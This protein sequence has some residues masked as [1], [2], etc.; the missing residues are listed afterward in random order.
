MASNTSRVKRREKF[1][2]TVWGGIWG[3]VVGAVI[4]TVAS[5][6]AV[7]HDL[8]LPK[9][10]A[11]AVETPSGTE[12]DQARPETDPDIPG[13][14]T[15]P[16]AETAAITPATPA[17]ADASPSFDTQS[18]AAPSTGFDGP[19]APGRPNVPGSADVALTNREG[20]RPETGAAPEATAPLPPGTERPVA[21]ARDVPLPPVG[22]PAPEVT[23]T[24]VQSAAPQGLGADADAES[25][26]PSAAP[27]RVASEAPQPSVPSIAPEAPEAREETLALAE[28]IPAD[29]PVVAEDQPE[30]PL[31]VAQ[32][33]APVVPETVAE[34]QPETPRPAAPA[35]EAPEPAPA[36]A[37][38]PAI[39]DAGP[40]AS[41]T[42]DVEIAEV[43]ESAPETAA[44]APLALAPEVETTA[45]E[46]AAPVPAEPRQ[47]ATT[48]PR[49]IET[50]RDAE[51]APIG[52]AEAQAPAPSIGAPATRL[53]DGTA[54]SQTAEESAG[55]MESDALVANR[56]EFSA[57]PELAQM[58][59][60][61]LHEGGAL[62]DDEALSNLPTEVS[63]AVDAREPNA[64]AIADAYRSAG[65]EIVLIPALPPRPTPQDV[66]IAL[67]ANLST[68]A[69]TVAVMDPGTAGF[70]NDRA[71][72]GQVIAVLAETGHGLITAS[73]GLNTAQQIASRFEVPSALIFGDL[74]SASD[75]GAA[76][77]AL[78]RV[79][80]RARQ[81]SGIILVGPAN[82]AT[83]AALATWVQGRASAG[84]QLA[85]VS[86]VIAPTDASAEAEPDT[87]A[88]DDT[89]ADANE[90]GGLP[91]V[92]RLPQIRSLP[93]TSN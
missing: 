35:V 36:L 46:P 31:N 74:G 68:I 11:R 87:A 89:T 45:Q 88:G 16:G 20:L 78:D 80:F 37:E 66:E 25:L 61:L 12:F 67:G 48:E 71:A 50:S 82:D 4:I 93:G 24:A 47:I 84:L 18:A 8:L 53:N 92:R 30:T 43:R 75:T 27:A 64:G 90:T 21:V 10:E 32:D 39:P 72:V 41:E 33:A 6:L 26:V 40:V 57:D 81:E 54:E 5:Q 28:P 15:V 76:E 85:P 77:R 38:T 52:V 69:G 59:V 79:A 1:L 65:R 56:Q 23:E 58:A 2:S 55:A 83:R 34:S 14:E 3:V 60:I 73:R 70:Q 49:R 17:P 44:E 63:F 13:E 62:P 51:T 19:A 86:A 91:T 9:P 42:A 7:R 22:E 29:V